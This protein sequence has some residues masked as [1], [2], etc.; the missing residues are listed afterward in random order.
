MNRLVQEYT[1]WEVS[2]HE[3]QGYLGRCVV[4]CKRPDTLDLTDATKEER[5]ELFTILTHLKAALAA[6]FKPDWFNYA[7]LGNGVRHLHC[8]VIPRYA[9]ERHFVGYEFRDER[10]GHNYRTDHSFSIPD[11]ILEKIRSVLSGA[12]DGALD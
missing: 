9:S 11:Y 5:D 3:N 6:A 2:L 10:Y 7:F 12:L 4:W 1:Y 8:H